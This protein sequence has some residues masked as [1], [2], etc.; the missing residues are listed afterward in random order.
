MK[1]KK[2]LYGVGINDADYVVQRKETIGYVNGKQKQKLVWE[3]PY[4]RVWAHML[5]RCYSPKYQEKYPTYKG[6]SVSEEWITFSNFRAW[7]EEQDFVDKQLDKD[8]LFEGN[9]VYS[10]E[11]CVFVT[12]IVNSFTI[13]RGNDRGE[14]LIGVHWDKAKGKFVSQCNN[15]FT[16]KRGN[17]GRFTCELEAHQTWLK[18]KL[19][20]AH[21]LAAE[22]TDER[23]AKALI[24]RYTNYTLEDSDEEDV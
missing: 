14:W 10:A 9:K 11:T 7:M 21:M 2:L 4:Y 24:E 23:V 16:K 8:L 12:S 18:R 13:D 5:Q 17:L 1:A 20:L 15:P 3:C 6:C 19:E 22:Q